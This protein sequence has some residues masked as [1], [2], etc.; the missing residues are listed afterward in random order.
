MQ[1][2]LGT[3]PGGLQAI[4]YVR[5]HLATQCGMDG[6]GRNDG[7]TT[8]VS[9]VEVVPL[10]VRSVHPWQLD[11]VFEAG[12]LDQVYNQPRD[13]RVFLHPV[14]NSEQAYWSL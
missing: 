5:C 14:A 7:Y 3:G 6:I 13:T 8:Q 2:A 12:I 11:R 9:L 10:V 1:F 4:P